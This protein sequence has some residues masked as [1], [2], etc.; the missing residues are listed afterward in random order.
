MGAFTST[1][2]NGS[3]NW[4]LGRTWGVGVVGSYSRTKNAAESTDSSYPGGDTISAGASLQH[5]I[6]ERINASVGYQRLHE[7][8]SAIPAIATAP[9]SDRV[10]ISISYQFSRPIG[11]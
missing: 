10:Y 6:T 5:S 1:S 4:R 11:R 3:G 7:N 9:D 8:Y 2:V